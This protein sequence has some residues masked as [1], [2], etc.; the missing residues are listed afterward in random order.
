MGPPCRAAAAGP[1]CGS[2]LVQSLQP[3]AFIQR[4]VPSSARLLRKTFIATR[5]TYTEDCLPFQPQ[6]YLC[7]VIA[8][9]TTPPF[10]SI[11]S[12]ILVNATPERVS[13]LPTIIRCLDGGHVRKRA[14]CKSKAAPASTKSSRHCRQVFQV[15]F[16]G[17]IKLS[18]S[19]AAGLRLTREAHRN[20][21][22]SQRIAVQ[23]AL[24]AATWIAYTV[25]IRSGASQHALYSR[26]GA[27]C[28]E[29]SLSGS[30]AVIQPADPHAAPTTSQEA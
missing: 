16:K 9:L 24:S 2:G 23:L 11:H 22:R 30:F 8:S 1:E 10:P 4:R 19:P 27:S 13:A 29:E 5:A 12:H 28:D 17:I 6:H 21:Q 3:T 18:D 25:K 7:A 26:A 15:R 20:R 14:G